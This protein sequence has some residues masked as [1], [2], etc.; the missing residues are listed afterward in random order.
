[1]SRSPSGKWA[2]ITGASS[3]IGKALAFEF[4]AGGYNILITARNETE[5]TKVAK[6]CAD[7]YHVQTEVVAADLSQPQSIDRLLNSVRDGTRKIDVLVNN[8]GFGI[9]GDF[10]ATDIEKNVELLNVQLT[11]A[12]RLT[13]AVLP[14]MIAQR[15]GRVLNVA[16]VYSWA[17]VPFQS[18]YAAC[19]AFLGS[20]SASLQNELAGTGVTVTVFAPG[21]TQTEFRSR[22]GIEAKR[23]DA[24]ITAEEA[25][26]I[27][28]VETLRGKPVV[29]PGFL[30]RLFVFLARRLPM[31][32]VPGIVR[33]INRQRLH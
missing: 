2:V 19:K 18:V 17:P 20:F 26:K 30:N 1:M 24:G 32:S 33:R 12:L 8:A 21:V 29:V 3:G 28:Y 31:T 27:A 23:E 10:A 4:A 6:E 7:R 14:T 15:Y 9:H 5:L 11:A 22:A 25:A 16:S 13:R